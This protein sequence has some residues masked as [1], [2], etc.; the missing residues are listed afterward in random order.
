MTAVTVT[1][2][3]AAAPGRV[4]DAWVD[5]AQFA[6]WFGTDAV[7]VPLDTL[8]WEVVP[9]ATW[10][11]TTHLPDGTTKDW[12]GTFLEVVPGERLVL[13]MTDEVG[14]DPGEPLVVT[15]APASAPFT[16]EMTLVQV[17]DW[18]TPEAEA[19][20]QA[21]YGAFFDVLDRLVAQ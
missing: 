20:L 17:G 4:W 14:T 5:P 12:E 8:R 19:A 13:T 18:I 9:G 2:V 3:V 7:E 1:R 21:G 6:T 10:A 11:A 16:T 15:F